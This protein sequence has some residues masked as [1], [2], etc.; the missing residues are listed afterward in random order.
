MDRKEINSR[1]ADVLGGSE[2]SYEQLRYKEPS[3]ASAK[4]LKALVEALDEGEQVMIHGPQWEL[5][6]TPDLRPI[7]RGPGNSIFVIHPYYFEGLWVFDDAEVG[8]RREP[9]VSSTTDVMNVLTEALN[10]AKQ[11]GVTLQFSSQ[12]FPGYS[13]HLVKVREEYEGWWYKFENTGKE[14]WLGNAL[15]CYFDR[16]PDSIYISILDQ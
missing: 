5:E 4:L 3:T 12:P 10:D 15:L 2:R 7:R 1:L 14:G 8:L 11:T 6:L 16:A 13:E 9:F